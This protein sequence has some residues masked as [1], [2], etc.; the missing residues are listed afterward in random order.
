[1]IGGIKVGRIESSRQVKATDC[2]A[3]C[4]LLLVYLLRDSI[5][6]GSIRV[7]YNTHTTAGTNTGEPYTATAELKFTK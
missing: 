4:V 2:V 6:Y 1:M 3:I 5:P 7:L